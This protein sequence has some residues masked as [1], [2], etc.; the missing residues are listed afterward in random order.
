MYEVTEKAI[1]GDC[2]KAW[3][4]LRANFNDAKGVVKRKDKN[5]VPTSAD[6]AAIDCLCR[7]WDYA[8]EGNAKD[9]TGN[10]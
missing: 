6:F 2:L 5:Y 7:E 1:D 4:I 9:G 8:Y 3:D 10:F